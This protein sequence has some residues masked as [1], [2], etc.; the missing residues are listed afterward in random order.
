MSFSAR[1]RWN[2]CGSARRCVA[3][4][5]TLDGY[6]VAPIGRHVFV[7][8]EDFPAGTITSATF[9]PVLNQSIALAQVF[10]EYAAHGTALE[11]GFVD[12]LVRRVPAVVGPLAAYDPQE[13]AGEGVNGP[14][15]Y[16]DFAGVDG[17]LV[18]RALFGEAAARLSV[19]Q[20]LD[21]DWDGSPCSV[22]RLCEGNFRIG[23]LRK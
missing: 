7:P 14:P 4:G 8:G 16:W 13:D 5:L 20:S 22:L 12:G 3:V 11:V 15:S 9:S 21:T 23:A 6:E 1:R 19:W 2:V 17:G 18:A 10:P